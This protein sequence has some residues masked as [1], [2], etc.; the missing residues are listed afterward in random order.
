MAQF[1]LSEE[2]SVTVEVRRRGK[3]VK[4]F[5]PRL[6]GGGRTHTLRLRSRRR[7]DYKL[8]LTASSPGKTDTATLTGRRL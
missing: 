8:N 7:G 5:A 1:R 4:R 3:L 2:A 6:Y